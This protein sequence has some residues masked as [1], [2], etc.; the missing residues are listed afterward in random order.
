[1]S[2]NKTILF[3]DFDVTGH[4]AEY[5]NHILA[6]VKNSTTP[7][8]YVFLL[9]E[10]FKKKLKVNSKNVQYIF[11]NTSEFLKEKS[12]LIRTK[13]E[14]E[15]IQKEAKE[16]QVSDIFL[17]NIDPYQIA[18]VWQKN[19]LSFRYYGI[20]FSPPTRIQT[21]DN[22]QFLSKWKQIF[23]KK[24]K[25]QQLNFCVK[26]LNGGKI[27][28]LNDEKV[29]S[30]LNSK[31]QTQNEAF[32]YLPDPIQQTQGE[33]KQDLRKKFGISRKTTVLLAFGSIIPRKNLQRCIR[34]LASL[35]ESKPYCLLIA[36][37]GNPNYIAD[38][39][40]EYDEN[41]TCRHQLIIE[42]TFLSESE[43]PNYFSIADV[44]L[45]PYIN[46]YGSSGVLGHAMRF[47]K[48]VIAPK[49]GLIADLVRR[50][51]LGLTVNPLSQKAIESAL[52]KSENLTIGKAYTDF[53]HSH[54]PDAFAKTILE[55]LSE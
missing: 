40:K 55:T 51:D 18:L 10:K 15:F 27:F 14:L 36:G 26:N 6:T 48:P 22:A 44:V 42:N 45:M 2:L 52:I 33:V 31:I 46:F 21:P 8:S 37:K 9:N 53:Y 23:R 39:Q 3:Y 43:I 28:V 19:Q 20:L 1:M 32:R 12:L 30:I 25:E 29:V 16:N 17:L 50:Y 4:H 41:S 54:S 35:P 49:V 7:H 34:A 47:G 11:F 13:K 5:V 38:L 24:R